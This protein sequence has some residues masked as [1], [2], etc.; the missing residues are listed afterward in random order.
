MSGLLAS[1]ALIE[2]LIAVWPYSWLP[3]GSRSGRR[4]RAIRAP[5]LASAAAAAS[6][7]G[8]LAGLRGSRQDADVTQV[9][10]M[11]V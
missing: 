2:G 1:L 9:C 6:A 11:A 10:V 3:A 4:S 5:G 7:R 8:R